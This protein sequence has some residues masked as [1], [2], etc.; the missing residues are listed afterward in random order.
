MHGVKIKFKMS[1][2]RVR[3]E[4]VVKYDALRSRRA[5]PA[6]SAVFADNQ[7]AEQSEI[8]VE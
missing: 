6:Y 1:F 4:N 8:D 2:Q 7:I 3:F 5:A